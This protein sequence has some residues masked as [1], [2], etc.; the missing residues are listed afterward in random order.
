M[1]Y[2][3]H[4]G[5]F[6]PA[7]R[8]NIGLV[9]AIFTRIR[10]R[11]RISSGSSAFETD[12]K[13]IKRALEGN[14]P[15][16]MLFID[17]FGKGTTPEEGVAIFSAVLGTLCEKGGDCPRTVA[18]THFHE[19]YHLGLLGPELPIKWCT[20]DFLEGETVTFLYR[21]VSGKALDSL[22]INCAKLAGLPETIV[23]R[24]ERLMHLYSAQVTPMS[25]RY[26]KF[27]ER[28][29]QLS[30]ALINGVQNG[31]GLDQLKS[32]ATQLLDSMVK[33]NQLQ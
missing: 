30:V 32:F 16:S 2:L 25:I 5:S 20:M 26:S 27:D 6:V 18:I 17:E 14:S 21:V 1:V 29:E 24:A 4:V 3:A 9:D 15:R 31:A 22:G 19:V 33:R 13:Q 10:T 11:E 23:E 8:A 7:K 28:V 12:L